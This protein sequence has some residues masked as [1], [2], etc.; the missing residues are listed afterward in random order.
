MKYTV[1]IAIDG[2]IDIEVEAASFNEAFSKANAELMFT[3]LKDMEVVGSIPVYAQ[4]ED[5]AEKDY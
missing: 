1:S 3:S 4:R 5:G 2:R